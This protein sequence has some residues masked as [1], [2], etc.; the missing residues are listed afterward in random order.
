MLREHDEKER[1]WYVAGLPEVAKV[2]AEVAD[3]E[4]ERDAALEELEKA[5]EALA[6]AQECRNAYAAALRILAT[7]VEAKGRTESANLIRAFVEDPGDPAEEFVAAL[8]AAKKPT[9]GNTAE[10]KA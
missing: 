7:Q 5:R 1:F 6:A 4:A 8:A 3:L 2:H 9:N 10:L